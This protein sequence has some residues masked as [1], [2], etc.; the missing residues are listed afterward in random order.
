MATITNTEKRLLTGPAIPGHKPAKWLPGRNP[1]DDK[2][3]KAA[4]NHATIKLWLREK[5]ITVDVKDDMPDPNEPPPAEVLAEFTT[6]EL[7]R[8]L[9][10]QAI[11]VQ[12]HPALEAELKKRETEELQARANPNAGTLKD[13]TIEKASPVIAAETSV[14]K[15]DAWAEADHR[16]GIK[17]L[18]G[19]R[20]VELSKD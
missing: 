20:L 17:D 16:Q 8:A 12:W 15:L 7:Q 5:L 1:L 6:R 4:K 19:E 9:K 13:L 10:D 3:W 2:Y 18:I 14:D 11:P